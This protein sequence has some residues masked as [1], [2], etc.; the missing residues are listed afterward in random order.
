MSIIIS[1]FY[2]LIDIKQLTVSN[3]LKYKENCC[4]VAE[5]IINPVLYNDKGALIHE[6]W[7]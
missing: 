2:N 5:I 1:N 6:M 3:K 7:L 4:K